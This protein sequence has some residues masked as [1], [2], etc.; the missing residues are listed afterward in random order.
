V[1]TFLND[2]SLGEVRKAVTAAGLP[3]YPIGVIYQ[4]PYMVAAE[5]GTGTLALYN[6]ALDV[7]W[8]KPDLKRSIDA[9]VTAHEYAHAI[10]S[11][12]ED[13]D[14]ELQKN[15]M[16]ILEV[17]AE[18]DP[19]KEFVFGS[20]LAHKVI[21]LGYRVPEVY[22]I[23]RDMEYALDPSEVFARAIE[24]YVGSGWMP[25]HWNVAMNPDEGLSSL[26][27]DDRSFQPIGAAIARE[28]PPQGSTKR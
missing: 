22:G 3:L 16:N 18:S 6:P 12:A 8:R 20:N 14:L 10:F 27:W 15:I 2:P 11:R 17:C 23:A 25:H 19:I 13:G 7:I 1:N 9:I 21:S 24:Q 26:R 28:F 4:L 5:V